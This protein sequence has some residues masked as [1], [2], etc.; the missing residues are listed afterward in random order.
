MQRTTKSRNSFCIP[1]FRATTTSTCKSIL[2][3]I[4][5]FP[6]WSSKI[7]KLASYVCRD[8]TGNRCIVCYVRNK[9]FDTSGQQS[10]SVILRYEKKVLEEGFIKGKPSETRAMWIM[11]GFAVA[12]V[13]HGESQI[14]YTNNK[15]SLDQG[16]KNSLPHR[17]YIS[18]PSLWRV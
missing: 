4:L 18:M 6:V 16:Q 14:G 1:T 3:E 13:L 12:F 9:M 11:Q 5:D 15:K 2:S 10:R 17:Q 8:M 7:Q